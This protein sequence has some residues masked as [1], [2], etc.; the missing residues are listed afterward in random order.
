MPGVLAAKRSGFWQQGRITTYIRRKRLGW[1]VLVLPSILLLLLLFI[2]PLLSLT[3]LSIYDQGFTLE[4]Y[5][6]ILNVPAYRKVLLN[7]VWMATVVTLIC[8]VLGYTLAYRLTT[9]PRT[10]QLAILVAVMVPFWTSLLVRSYGWMVILHPGGLIN[11]FLLKLG[12]IDRPLPLVH[13]T[14]GVLIGMTHIM[15]PYMVL[16]IAAVMQGIDQNL[17]RAARSLGASPWQCFFWVFLPLTLPG[18]YAGVLLVFIISLGFF[19][20]PALLG[21]TKDI[22]IAQLIQFNLSQVLNW[23]F[24]AALS[25]V[26]L[27]VTLVLYLGASRWLNLRSLW[28]EIR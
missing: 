4:H 3:L 5:W 16:P 19:V 28:G 26:L 12:L 13:N 25:A 9:A 27:I 10:W 6:R 2:Y 15:L 11:S 24:A 18:V 1:V 8:L 22:L 14:T 17:I 20:L 21:G 7:T 23:G